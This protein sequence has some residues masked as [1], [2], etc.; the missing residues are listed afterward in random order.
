MAYQQTSPVYQQQLGQGQ[1]QQQQ[2]QQDIVSGDQYRYALTNFRIAH[3]KV[4]QQRTQL[5]EQE[6][7]VAQLRS[8]ISLLEGGSNTS[9]GGHNGNTVDDFSIKNSASQLDKL[10]NRWAADVIRAP[11]VPLQ[12]LCNAILSDVVSGMDINRIQVPEATPMQVQ[13]YLRHAMA[14]T[15]S[16][17]IINCLIVTNSTE[18]NIQLTRIHE[19]IFARDPTVASVWRRQTFSA[20]VDSCTPDISLT[21]LH[22]QVP[23]LMRV[24]NGKIP[25]SGGISILE[26]AYTFSRMLHGSGSASND[27]FYRA[28]V[29]ELGSVLYP[30][31][32][33]LVKRC[34]KS[35]RGETDRVGAT[36]FPGLVKITR[37]GIVPGME[38]NMQTV[39]R[40]A[41]VICECALGGAS[42]FSMPTSMSSMPLY[43][44]HLQ[45]G[46]LE[47]AAMPNIMPTM[48]QSIPMMAGGMSFQAGYF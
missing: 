11:P 9:F 32:I 28:F 29:P 10:I 34:L 16:E 37:G 43:D 4:E 1:Q 48:T 5:E 25:A 47:H 2:Q 18:A 8:R 31:Q 24:L 42:M 17:G 21:I 20:A 39:V 7:Q 19:H 27:A 30:R 26:S 44:A 33:E 6:R 12:T 13:S 38:E 46:I 15:I 35:E 45:T 36:I 3:E 41:Q 22:E 23:E 40:R 14:E